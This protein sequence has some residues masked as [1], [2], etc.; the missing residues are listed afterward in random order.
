MKKLPVLKIR[1]VLLGFFVFVIFSG[2]EKIQLGEPFDCRIGTKYLLENKIVFSIDSIS[3]YRCPKDLV[4][5][6]SGDVDLYFDIDINLLKT[7]T[8]IRLFRNNPI[9]LGGYD[10]KIL[11]VNPRLNSGQTIDQRDYRIRLVIQE[12]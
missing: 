10:W 3:D 4:C 8:V 12:N 5:F 6:W 9:S 11:E 1:T 7:D 2:C